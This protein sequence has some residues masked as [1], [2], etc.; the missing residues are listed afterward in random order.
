MGSRRRQA[1]NELCVYC[2]AAPATTTDH[3][4]PKVLWG[5]DALDPV[6]VTVPACRPCQQRKADGDA[7]LRDFVNLEINGS[8]H[9]NALRQMAKVARAT[10]RNRSRLGRAVRDDGRDQELVTDAGIYLGQ[11][12]AVPIDRDTMLRTLA[13][14][15]RGLYY[16]ETRTMLPTDVPVQVAYVQPLRVRSVLT[17]FDTK[18]H[19]SAVMKGNAI[20]GWLS[21]RPEDA[22]LSTMWLLEFNAGV[23]FIGTTGSFAESW[24]RHLEEEDERS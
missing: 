22:P 9:P 10:T 14:I 1:G 8:R 6:M 15:V 5:D 18:P 20:A 7:Y 23:Y 21:F 2:G 12:Y 11:V 13:L 17:W 3:V 16:D 24:R 4:F 19:T